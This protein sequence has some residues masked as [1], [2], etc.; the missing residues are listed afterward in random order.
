MPSHWVKNNLCAWPKKHF[1]KCIEH[2]LQPNEIEFD[3]YP[4]R[5]LKRDISEYFLNYINCI[6]YFK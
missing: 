2:S 6:Y 5:V 4:A 3:Y 1:K